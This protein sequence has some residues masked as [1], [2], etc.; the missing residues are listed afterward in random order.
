MTVTRKD[1]AEK[2]GVSTAT[3]SNVING[4]KYVSEELSQKVKKA[5]K[6]LNYKPNLVAQSL[7]TK[8][9]KQ[10]AILID[11]ITNPYFNEI[12]LG[13]E[14]EAK[15]RNYIVN[16]GI[17]NNSPEEYYQD[18]YSRQIDGIYMVVQLSNIPK[19]QIN[20]MLKNGTVMVNSFHENPFEIN[21]SSICVDYFGGMKKIFEHL[22]E[23]G[24]KKIGY[25]DFVEPSVKENTSRYESYRFYLKEF[26]LEYNENYLVFGQPPYF[27]NYEQGY[28]DMK[29]LLARNTD[30]TAVI[31][32]NDYMA[33]GALEAI[34]D[35]GL[36]VPEDIS[37]VSFDN[38]IFSKI[39]STKLTSLHVD[40]KE[41]GVKA[42][43]LIDEMVTNNVENIK[44]EMPTELVVRE[45]TGRVR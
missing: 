17:G 38:T 3:V 7:T 34:K 44:I 1:V 11:D 43:Q 39:S 32:I 30:I 28:R 5:I 33:V 9:S 41:Q 24:H 22:I 26:N 27:S 12:I 35:F 29:K 21:S 8:Q 42:M 25:I 14:E 36:K 45:S 10:V 18:L 2:A 23:L 40:K 37:V 15:K 13:F 16:I 4:T 19:E 31:V 6:E 20:E